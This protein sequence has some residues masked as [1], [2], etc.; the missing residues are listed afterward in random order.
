MIRRFPKQAKAIVFDEFGAPGKVLKLGKYELNALDDY[1]LGL[2]LVCAPINPSDI[3]Q[4]QGVYPIRPHVPGAIA[5]NEGLLKVAHV[6]KALASSWKVND[7]V[8]PK[9]ACF[10]TWRD[11]AVAKPEQ[12]LK[13]PEGVPDLEAA[14]LSVNLCSAY[15]MLK[16]FDCEGAVIQNAANSGVGRAII[17]LCKAFGR[18]S[19]NIVRARETKEAT[20]ELVCELKSL[21]ADIIVVQDDVIKSDTRELLKHAVPEGITLALNC[22]GGHV[23]VNMARLLRDSATLV[24]YGAMSREPF[25]LPASLFIFKDIR[26]RGF[27]MA[28]W[29]EEA[30]KTPDGAKAYDDMI[31]E[32]CRLIKD[33]KLNAAPCEIITWPMEEEDAENVF[34]AALDKAQKASLGKKIVLSLQ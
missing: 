18:K 33:G 24:T 14:T 30:D 13:I 5:G 22:V 32:L 28:R 20:E 1:S 27:W 26:L 34:F 7:R 6:G 17:Q 9:N 23:A 21:G 16:D 2:K 11:Y 25:N 3:N 4:I 19:V 31:N 10:G 12:L 8:I 15:R 29:K